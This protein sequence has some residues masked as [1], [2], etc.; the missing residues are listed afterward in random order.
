[1]LPPE[2]T[3]P[4]R[5]PR[6]TESFPARTAAAPTDGVVGVGGGGALG[7]DRGDEPVQVVVDVEDI[8]VSARRGERSANEQTGS[9]E[10]AMR[11]PSPPNSR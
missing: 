4:T 8:R 9:R 2:R 10:H 5:A 11:K 3:T 1:M 6:G 7:V